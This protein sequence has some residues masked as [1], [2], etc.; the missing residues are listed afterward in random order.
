MLLLDDLLLFHEEVFPRY[1][2]VS[3]RL[4]IAGYAL[5]TFLYLARFRT[6]ILKTEYT[7]L[8]LAL[9]FFGLSVTLD[10]LQYRMELPWHRLFEE[11]FKL[12]G[13]ANWLGYFARTSLRWTRGSL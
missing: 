4:T 10:Y 8:L 6:M 12:F 11:G 9:G 1:F 3:Q 2:N 5:V 13:I 7:V